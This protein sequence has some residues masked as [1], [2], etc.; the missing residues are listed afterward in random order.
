MKIKL[1]LSI[2]TMQSIVAGR[3]AFKQYLKVDVERDNDTVNLGIC[4]AG[5]YDHDERR[6]IINSFLNYLLQYSHATSNTVGEGG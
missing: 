6:E 1:P 4:V 2:Y 3:K 5:K